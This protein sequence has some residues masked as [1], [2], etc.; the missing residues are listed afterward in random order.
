MVLDHSWRIVSADCAARRILHLHDEGDGQPLE[1]RERAFL[2][3]FLRPAAPVRLPSSTLRLLQLRDGSRCA[4]LAHF[5]D[6][7]DR[8]DAELEPAEPFFRFADNLPLAVA[9]TDD[10]GCVCYA[11]G[12]VRGVYG[13]PAA[14]LGRRA[15]ELAQRVGE[16]RTVAAV[17]TAVSSGRPLADTFPFRRP[18]GSSG[19][20]LVRTTAMTY[21]GF[22]CGTIWCLIDAT[23]DEHRP[24]LTSKALWYRTV[25]TFQHELRNPLQTMQAVADLLR[26]RLAPAE[27]RLLAM[28]EQQMQMIGEYLSEQL[29]SPS[30][31][32]LTVSRLSDVVAEEIARSG[33]RLTTRALTFAHHRPHHEPRV[34]IHRGSMA[35]AFANIFRNSAQ[36]RA[37]ATVDIRYARGGDNLTC[38]VADNGPG[39]PSHGWMHDLATPSDHLGLAI[40]S[41][42]VESQGGTVAVDNAPD[43]GARVSIRLPLASA[44]HPPA[45]PVQTRLDLAADAEPPPAQ[46][47]APA[48]VAE[49]A[50]DPD[51]VSQRRRA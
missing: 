41:S 17:F 18:D 25:A 21:R 32:A 33:L 51:L 23:D 3:E 8:I 11:N 6:A 7:E 2:M 50:E 24:L 26:P 37:D 16:P 9:V 15:R 34:R 5:R 4:V 42:T 1:Q 47:Q 35:R 31:V 36:A 44:M 20:A 13:P 29:Q 12:N 48:G 38:V 14:L 46:A 45:R 49:R 30:Q 10:G 39:F 28:L 19:R 27:G 43:G 40:V 22:P